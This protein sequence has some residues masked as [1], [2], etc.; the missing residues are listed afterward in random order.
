MEY[1]NLSVSI[2]SFITGVLH[3]SLIDLV[4]ECTDYLDYDISKVIARRN[5]KLSTV[6]GVQTIPLNK[7]GE[8]NVRQK[9]VES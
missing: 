8:G 6:I 3:N 2:H 5:E 9:V 1:L 7:E 4:N